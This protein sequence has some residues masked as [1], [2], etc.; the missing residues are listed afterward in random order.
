M[1]VWVALAD[2]VPVDSEILA[3]Y[4]SEPAD[5]KAEIERLEKTRPYAD[6]ICIDAYDVLDGES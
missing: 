1:K 4:A 2:Y 3:V 6:T 5:T